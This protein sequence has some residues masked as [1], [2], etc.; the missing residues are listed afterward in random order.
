MLLHAQPDLQQDKVFLPVIVPMQPPDE[1]ATVREHSED[2]TSPSTLY[3]PNV[4]WASGN[5]FT[6][7]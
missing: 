7:L 1:V 4:A 3:L 6:R 2:I 5:I